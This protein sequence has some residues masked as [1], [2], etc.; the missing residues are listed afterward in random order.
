M[1]LLEWHEHR[2]RRRSFDVDASMTNLPLD[3]TNARWTSQS[4]HP[5]PTNE[6]DFVA[7]IAWSR[8]S[9]L[10]Q[11]RAPRGA[12]YQ[13][14]QG[15]WR[16][17][18][19]VRSTLLDS[20]S[21]ASST[22]ARCQRATRRSHAGA[23]LWIHD[24]QRCRQGT[25]RVQ[26]HTARRSG[27][28]QVGWMADLSFGLGR[29]R[30]LDGHLTRHSWRGSLW[31]WWDSSSALLSNR[32]MWHVACDRHHRRSGCHQLR[33]MYSCTRALA[34]G[35]QSLHTFPCCSIPTARSSRS[36]RP[37]HHCSGTRYA[38]ITRPHTLS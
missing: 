37:I 16:L 29:R 30:S 13:S 6:R 22:E 7:V 21:R 17:C 23:S 10:L 35:H 36:V 31:D 8:V 25:G 26:E 33:S 3:S 28:P 20:H 2:R 15:G 4:I 12:S 34:G 18:C 1:I 24:R 14:S 19:R 32:T 27:A 38:P 5:V 9:L 11:C